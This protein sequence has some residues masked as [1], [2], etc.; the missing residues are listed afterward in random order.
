M[1]K[2]WYVI[3]IAL[4]I[5][6]NPKLCLVFFYKNSTETIPPRNPAKSGMY[7]CR[8]SLTILLRVHNTVL[9]INTKLPTNSPKL[10]ESLLVKICS[11]WEGFLNIFLMPKI[12]DKPDLMR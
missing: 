1:T 9:K 5:R 12:V 8:Y 6:N 4:A 7:F 3:S 10:I 2:D 11:R